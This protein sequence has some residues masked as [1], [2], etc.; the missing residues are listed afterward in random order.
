MTTHVPM[1]VHKPGSSCQRTD[2]LLTASFALLGIA[3][4]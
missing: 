1:K 2:D 4:V 3:V